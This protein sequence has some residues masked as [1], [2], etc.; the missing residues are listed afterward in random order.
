MRFLL[1]VL[2]ALSVAPAAAQSA[3]PVNDIVTGSV[4]GY[5]RPGFHQFA[6]DTAALE[7]GVSKLCSGPAANVLGDT[8][9]KFRAVVLS[10][11]RIEFLHLGPLTT[12]DRA[13]RLLFWPDSKG[14]ALK[15]VQ[16][17]LAEKDVTAVDPAT[18]Q[19]KSVAMQGLGALEFVLFG[20]GADTLGTADG[21]FRCSYGLAIA[22]LVSGIAATLD[23]EWSDPSPNGAVAHMLDPKPDAQDY[24]TSKEV[25][26]KLAGSLVIGT[27]TVRDQRIA[28][29]VGAAEGK[30]RPKS[31]LFWRS[32]MTAQALRANFQ[33]LKDLFV[34]GKFSEATKANNS[35]WI[36]NSALFEFDN[37]IASAGL[38]SE[39]IE[40]AITGN[41]LLQLKVMTN[42]TRS[43]D[44]LLGENLP[45]ALGLT[46][47]FSQLDGD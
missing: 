25:L 24:R 28:P 47:G 36:S 4:N 46:M 22:T 37:A 34:I 32:G 23:T 1:A 9:A 45:S 38:I 31:A 26:E 13:E 18:L 42:I 44:T 12:G 11:S 29:I 3:I 39:P 16:Q 33:G 15:Q 41:G 10:F 43:L 17:V 6:T 35:G 40:T 21:A 5:I 2:F 20:T 14:I 27:E 30:P 7:A 19:K 8:Q